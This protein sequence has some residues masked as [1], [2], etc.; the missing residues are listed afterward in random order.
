[1]LEVGAGVGTFGIVGA[2]TTPAFYLGIEPELPLV[3]A[4]RGM[5]ARFGA[6]RVRFFHGD[7]SQM[8]FHLYDAIYLFDPEVHRIDGQSHRRSD[9]RA[10]VSDALAWQKLAEMKPGTRI[11][12][13]RGRR[14]PDGCHPVKAEVVGS[15]ELLLF[16]RD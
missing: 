10:G 3:I 6:S 9:H 8:E 7:V 11:L 4:A 12:T 1:V 14:A 16:E 5:A 2:L 13:A 15:V